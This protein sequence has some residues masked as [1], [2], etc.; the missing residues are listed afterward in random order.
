MA[1]NIAACI[2]SLGVLGLSVLA[3]KKGEDIYVL[4]AFVVLMVLFPMYTYEHHLVFLLFPCAIL[5][6]DWDDKSRGMQGISIFT[7]FFLFWPLSWWKEMQRIVPSMQWWF[8][9]SKC[10]AALLLMVL[11]CYSSLYS[12]DSAR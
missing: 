7:C 8:Q 4:G 6:Q 1:K 3:W 9:E 2:N 12:K 10:L 11:L 5:L